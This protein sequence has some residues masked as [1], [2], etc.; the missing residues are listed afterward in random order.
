MT[1]DI[2][3]RAIEAALSTWTATRETDP[4]V[5]MRAAISAYEKAMW[6]PIAEAIPYAGLPVL[7]ADLW[8]RKDGTTTYSWVAS[9][10]WDD[11]IDGRWVF[12]WADLDPD[13]FGTPTHFMPLP[14]PPE[15]G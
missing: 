12:D 9:G 14:A 11:E 10:Y 4:R 2:K 8:K 5:W 1:D 15:V 7:G 6:R 13:D 3:E